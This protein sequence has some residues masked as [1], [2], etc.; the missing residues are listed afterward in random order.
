MGLEG[1]VSKRT[2]APY[3]SGQARRGSSRRTRPAM[4]CAGSAR[5][6]GDSV[7]GQRSPTGKQDDGDRS[8][9]ENDG[10]DPGNLNFEVPSWVEWHACAAALAKKRSGPSRRRMTGAVGAGV[11]CTAR[12]YARPSRLKDRA[13][14]IVL[15]NTVLRYKRHRD[16]GHH[17]HHAAS[18]ADERPYATTSQ[19]GERSGAPRA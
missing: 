7:P 3:R 16:R 13:T 8:H 1:I 5:R 10:G 11:W 4:R 9:A 17:R 15:E 2:D 6:S 18:T 19:P 14:T 12:W